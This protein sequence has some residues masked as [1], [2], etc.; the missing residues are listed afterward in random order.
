[1]KKLFVL[2]LLFHAFFVEAQRWDA[3]LMGGFTGYQGDLN[4]FVNA[5]AK[6]SG[7]AGGL[8]VRKYFNDQFAVRG[9]FVYGKIIADDKNFTVPEWR[10]SRGFSFSSTLL[11][12]SLQ[13]E[14]TLWHESKKKDQSNRK[15]RLL[16]PYALVGVG[17][18][19]TS[20]VT[21]FNVDANGNNPQASAEAIQLDKNAVYSNR[22]IVVPIGGGLRL[23][24]SDRFSLG[25]ELAVRPTFSDYVD[26]IS[27]AANPKYNDWYATGMVTLGVTFGLPDKDKDGV[28]DKDDKCPNIPGLETLHGCPDGDGDGVTDSS[29]KC[30]DVA[31]KKTAKG[32][33]DK[34]SDGVTDAEDKC[35]E[36]YGLTELNGCPDFDHDNVPDKEDKCPEEYGLKEEDGCPFKDRDKDGVSDSKDI[37]PDLKGIAKFGGCPDTDA[38]DI[39]D[40]KD[41]C[42]TQP[43][44][45]AFKGC[46]DTDADGIS[47]LDDRCPT[48][49]GPATNRGCPIETTPKPISGNTPTTYYGADG[50]PYYG[51]IK[52]VYFTSGKSILTGENI[53]IMDDIVLYLNENP[54]YDAKING[55]T[56]NTG[57]HPANLSLSEYRAKSCMDY[58]VKKGIA[59]SRMTFAGF[60]ADEAEADNST[61]D[62]RALNRRVEFMVFKR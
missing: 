43:G 45:V 34:D 24:V 26:G 36:E 9:N 7:L 29:D 30:P 40:D 51:F 53:K 50:K 19:I 17:I 32:C 58:L 52:K 12:T 22:H 13:G 59:P 55:H 25:A 1:M 28:T 4:K 57:A 54:E 27:Q 18:G 2:Y 3:G 21:N 61:E 15:K 46:P 23:N 44:T 47:D 16:V 35:P 5:T 62:G 6:T 56:D 11:E 39:S 20:P 41:N 49:A 37:C 10:P 42:P 14:I 31:G 60:A 48:S 8:F 38:D 33:P